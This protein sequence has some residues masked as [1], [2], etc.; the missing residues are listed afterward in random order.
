MH[1]NKS[2]VYEYDALQC[3]NFMHC[4]THD[5]FAYRITNITIAR[6]EILMHV[7][8][9]QKMYWQQLKL[10]YAAQIITCRDY[11]HN[12]YCSRFA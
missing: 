7:Y 2:I 1:V 6:V 4:C 5:F 10:K 12:A 11:Y 8:A 3:W 9:T